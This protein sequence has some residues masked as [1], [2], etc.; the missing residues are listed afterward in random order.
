MSYRIPTTLELFLAHLARLEGEIGQDSPL[1][2]KAFLRVLAKAEAALDIGHYKFSADAALQNLALT[3][4]GIGLD[5]IGLDN[6]TPRKQAQVA[7]LEAEL[8]ALAGTI[9]PSTA[10]FVGD[11]NG[12]RYHPEEDVV[13]AAGVAVLSLRCVDPGTNGNLDLTDTLSI[14]AQIAGAETVADVTDTIQLGVDQETDADYRP[15]VLFAQRAITGGSNATDH[16]IWAQAVVGVRRAFP[17][18]GRP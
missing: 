17:Y 18:A 2:D 16:K 12:L 13:A 7:I 14:S 10:D 8:P 3:A 6:A 5:R 1:N 15:R 11:A 9:I 4:T